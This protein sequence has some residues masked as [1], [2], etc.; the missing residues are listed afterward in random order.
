[1]VQVFVSCAGSR[2]GIGPFH[3]R[4]KSPRFQAPRPRRRPQRL[5]RIRGRLRC[6]S[7]PPS[8]QV[9]LRP[10]IPGLHVQIAELP[11]P[12]ALRRTCQLSWWYFREHCIY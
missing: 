6:S 5:H 1:M 4:L 12:L 9:L 2:P 11:V 8:P 3:F 7:K 10:G